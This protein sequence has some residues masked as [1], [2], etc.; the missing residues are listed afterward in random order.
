MAIALNRPEF[1]KFNIKKGSVINTKVS[2]PQNTIRYD[3]RQTLT[4]FLSQ[5][6]QMIMWRGLSSFL[7]NNCQHI[8]EYHQND[9]S[10]GI[11]VLRCIVILNL[12]NTFV[13]VFLSCIILSVFG[14]PYVI[15]CKVKF[16]L[17]PH[18]PITF[19]SIS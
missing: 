7:G 2:I 18:G 16:P 19:L 9:I 1:I 8:F 10:S 11:A 3:K 15:W 12:R 14:D 17:S 5:D 4:R 13:T 6:R